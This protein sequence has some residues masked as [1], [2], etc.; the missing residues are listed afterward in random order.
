MKPAS[1]G[2]IIIEFN[3]SDISS[4]YLINVAGTDESGKP[5]SYKAGL[6]VK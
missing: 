4:D 3:S 5:V 6:S 2:K 1:D